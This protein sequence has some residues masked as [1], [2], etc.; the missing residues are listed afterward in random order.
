MAILS[1][2]REKEKRIKDLK[3]SSTFGQ[4]NEILAR[5]SSCCCKGFPF[6]NLLIQTTVCAKISDLCSLIFLLT[7]AIAMILLAVFGKFVFISKLKNFAKLL[8]HA[9]LI[10]HFNELVHKTNWFL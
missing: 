4:V 9:R 1:S 7:S 8:N 10:L 6:T 3:D 2:I 5:F